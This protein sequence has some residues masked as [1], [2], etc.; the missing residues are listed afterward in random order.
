[1]KNK[2]KCIVIATSL[3]IHLFGCGNT[4][5]S[6]PDTI[7]QAK[8]VKLWS[9]YCMI[10][11][12]E[13]DMDQSEWILSKLVNE[14]NLSHDDIKV[15]FTYFDDDEAL[16]QALKAATETGTEAPDI[17]VVQSGKYLADISDLF[18]PIDEFISDDYYNSNNYW[19]TTLINGNHY[20]Y[21][22]TGVNVTYFAYNRELIKQA[23]L[24]FDTNPPKT[25][26]EFKTDLNIIKSAGITPITAGDYECNDLF[27]TV[28]AK[29]W[30]QQSNIDDISQDG[31][32]FSNDTGFINACEIAQDFWNNSYIV[33][34]YVTNEDTLSDIINGK[35]ALYNTFIFELG[36]L[37][38]EMGD[39]LGIIPVPDYSDN[40]NYKGLSLG[41]CNQC[42]SITANSQSKEES[43]DF[44]EWL[45]N[46]E[47]SI[48]LYNVYKGM[49][50]RNDVSLDELGWK[51]D[52]NYVEIEK[53][54][55]TIIT[56]PD[57]LVFG[58]SEMADAYYTYGPL[59][60]TGK[61]FPI[62][63]AKKIDDSAT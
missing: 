1:M 53:M 23:G 49:P 19:E 4:P 63:Y 22:T 27:S 21:P 7:E 57:Y 24:N 3:C 18:S 20:G 48:K 5:N 29:W 28:F 32:L 42:M 25:L 54:M 15:D 46:K 61:E 11:E 36:I 13:L 55:N 26:D 10:G 9:G 47:N 8:T 45:L 6:E 43:A 62:D 33:D 56:Y 34:N 41:S 44:I 59:L 58:A 52:D 38:A 51:S 14:Y 31:Y 40:C 2:I 30:F 12:D 37:E 16:V 35:A 50:I 60:I 39:N 17:A